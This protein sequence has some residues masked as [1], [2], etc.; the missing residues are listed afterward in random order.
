MRFPRCALA[1]LML[2]ATY[3]VAQ[4]APEPEYD[5]IHPN[6]LIALLPRDNREFRAGKPK[7]AMSGELA[8][9]ITSVSRVYTQR[10]TEELD[11]EAPKPTI[12]VKITDSSGNKHFTAMYG[13]I[14]ELGQSATSGFSNAI[15]L[16]GY[17]AI[18]NYREK[19]QVGTL[20]VFVGDRF[21]VQLAV[22]GVPQETMMEWWERIDTKRL[23]AL[24]V[25]PTPTPPA[26]PT[27]TQAPATPTPAKTP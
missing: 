1:A 4:D 6:K 17:P 20:S 24:A 22:K 15:S 9:K 14:A 5:A 8:S 11:E 25:R 10:E 26:T 16:D 18:R 13:K 12:T 2:V 27:D 3:A 7:G 21:L 19:D 23:A